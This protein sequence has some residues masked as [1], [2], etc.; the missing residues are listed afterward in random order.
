M[1]TDRK[2]QKLKCDVSL[3]DRIEA[4]DYKCNDII[5]YAERVEKYFNENDDGCEQTSIFLN[6]IGE[7]MYELLR[8]LLLT[9]EPASKTMR[10]L[11]EEVKKHLKPKPYVMTDRH[12]FYSRNQIEGETVSE[13]IEALRELCLSCDFKLYNDEAL[14]DRFVCGVNNANIK[15]KLLSQRDLTLKRA[16]SLAKKIEYDEV[17]RKN[18]KR[19]KS[20]PRAEEEKEPFVPSQCF[21]C[22]SKLH[23]SDD[24]RFKSITCHKCNMLGHLSKVCREDPYDIYKEVKKNH[25][26]KLKE[27]KLTPTELIKNKKNASGNKADE[28]EEQAGE[29]KCF[30]VKKEK[31]EIPKPGFSRSKTELN[32]SK[33]LKTKKDDSEIDSS[34]FNLISTKEPKENE[35]DHEKKDSKIEKLKTY[36]SKNKEYDTITNSSLSS[37]PKVQEDSMEELQSYLSSSGSSNRTLKSDTYNE[38]DDDEEELSTYI[39]DAYTE[40]ITESFD[41]IFMYQELDDDNKAEDA[42]SECNDLADTLALDYSF[43]CIET[44]SAHSVEYHSDCTETNV[45]LNDELASTRAFL[46]PSSPDGMRYHSDIGTA[47]IP[48][49]ARECLIFTSQ[50]YMENKL[51]DKDLG[52]DKYTSFKKDESKKS[53]QSIKSIGLRDTF[54]IDSC[55]KERSK[56]ENF[57]ERSKKKEKR[58]EYKNF[59]EKNE[60]DYE[61]DVYYVREQSEN[62]QMEVL[63]KVENKAM[64][65]H[66]DTGTGI[67]LISENTYKTSL[68]HLKLDKTNA[69]LKTYTEEQINVLGKVNVCLTNNGHVYPKLRL[70]V[71]SG[72]S[73]SLLGRNWL[74]KIRLDW[75]SLFAE[76]LDKDNLYQHQFH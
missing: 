67:S 69:V 59:E 57:S 62:K 76:Y 35:D 46:E 42:T 9:D 41:S 36:D 3:L 63:M 27:R 1:R 53:D 24:C 68:S 72:N 6:I 64:Q 55:E 20:K 21:R 12:E 47:Y 26:S 32:L 74:S 14:L 16:L 65:F 52:F 30:F 13:Y 33:N 61:E 71:V 25:T 15:N 70:Y 44:D 4:F 45:E 37:T 58:K 40:N 34:R 43:D 19:V 54:E 2:V 23:T 18:N 10:K 17:E 49:P 31:R 39:D 29:I 28:R 66:I 75:K 73:Q 51:T 38:M 8:K 60:I 11:R 50:I 5:E 56:K 22:H 7:E 48:E